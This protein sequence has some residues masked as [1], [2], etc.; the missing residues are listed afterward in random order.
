L[1]WALVGCLVVLFAAF[2]LQMIILTRRAVQKA[3]E[4]EVGNGA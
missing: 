1:R 4:P 2:L 3:E